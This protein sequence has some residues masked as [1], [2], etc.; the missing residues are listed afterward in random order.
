MATTLTI[1]VSLCSTTI[2]S[3][4]AAYGGYVIS[5]F[6]SWITSKKSFGNYI[7]IELGTRSENLTPNINNDIFDHEIKS[8]FPNFNGHLI[9]TSWPLV[10]RTLFVNCILWTLS[11][12]FCKIEL[13]SMATTL[14]ITVSLYSTTIESIIA[15]YGGYVISFS[16]SWITSKK[17]CGNYVYRIRCKKWKFDVKYKQWHLW[18]WNKKNFSKFQ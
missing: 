1:T 3:I 15:V 11:Q 12:L 9:F 8:T 13:N 17:S 5:F 14:T 18:L 2:E 16:K 7:Y 10:A 6:L 4:I